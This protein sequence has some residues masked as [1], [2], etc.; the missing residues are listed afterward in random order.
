[1][2]LTAAHE[3]SELTRRVSANRLREYSVSLVEDLVRSDYR[4]LREVVGSRRA[5]VVTTPTVAE[6]YGRAAFEALARGNAHVGLQV[7]ACDEQ[8]KSAEV[9]FEICRRAAEHGLDRKGL[10][11]GMGGGVCTDLV[12]MAA[13]LIR[14][15]VDYVKVPTT[16]IGQ[17]DAGI[18]IKGAINFAG[19]KHY[20]GCFT[21]PIHVAID[22]VFL[23]TVP[24]RLIRSGFA[25][26][27]KVAVACDGGL[28]QLVERYLAEPTGP[29]MR[30]IVWRTSVVLLDD[31][32]PN[33]FEDRST[34]RLADLGHTF[35]PLLEKA[36][37]YELHHGEAVAIDIA[38]SSVLATRL[39]LL[40]EPDR[41]RILVTLRAAGLA[42]WDPLLTEELCWSSLTE[43]AAHRAGNPNLVL[44]VAIGQA[45]FL[46]RID[47][48]SED[49][50]RASLE[51]LRDAA[52]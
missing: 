50:I 24:A 9:V 3:R 23:E 42:V 47:A 37:E 44:P 32:E 5:L 30:E 10:L 15:G 17:V 29:R 46:R 21:P 49:D 31:L 38:F 51:L 1:M 18:G 14:R 13:T 6:L 19:R 45:T 43:A 36:S 26:I 35:S 28:M 11:V 48:V 27:I 34:E 25:E 4:H 22:P 20:L 40:S 16:L 2:E 52:A 8:S 33:L 41:D 7:I 12:T 39:K